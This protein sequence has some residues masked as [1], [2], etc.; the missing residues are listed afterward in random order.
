[1]EFKGKIRQERG[2]QKDI[3]LI[4]KVLDFKSKNISLEMKK[5][6]HTIAKVQFRRKIK[7]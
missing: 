6:N 7:M 3:I 1:M 4:L 5:A 2:N